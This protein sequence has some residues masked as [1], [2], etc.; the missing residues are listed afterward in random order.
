[1][2]AI[3]HSKIIIVL[4]ILYIGISI[5][6][7][8]LDNSNRKNKKSSTS[9]TTEKNDEEINNFISKVESIN[10]D[11]IVYINDNNILYNTCIKLSDVMGTDYTGSA[12]VSQNGENINIWYSDGT[13]AVNNIETNQNEITKDDVEDS[14]NTEYYNNCG[15]SE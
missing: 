9:S 8:T 7:V 6:V 4:L 15:L 11:V 1:M 10:E 14:Y 12:Y 2:E 13:Y 5:L 3:K